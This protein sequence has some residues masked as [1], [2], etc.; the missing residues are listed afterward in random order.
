M[1]TLA[2][3]FRSDLHEPSVAQGVFEAHGLGNWMTPELVAVF[4]RGSYVFELSAGDF[5][6]HRIFGVTVW[7]PGLVKLQPDPS[8]GG[9]R[10]LEEA[11]DL[12][13]RV[14]PGASRRAR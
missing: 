11:L 2:R 5:L 14:A 3:E 12:V 13:D 1:S 7:G 8:A 4:R 10:T 9:F 6:D